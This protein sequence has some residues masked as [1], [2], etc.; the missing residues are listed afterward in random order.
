MN[1]IELIDLLEKTSAEIENFDKREEWT[2]Q[3]RRELQIRSLRL[4][5]LAQMK[6]LA[7]LPSGA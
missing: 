5:M 1:V 4:I 2:T 6:L 7:Y 3:E